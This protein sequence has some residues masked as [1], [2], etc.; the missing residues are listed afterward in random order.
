MR[1]LKDDE[2]EITLLMP[3]LNESETIGICVEK[4]M[5]SIKKNKLKGE[6]LIADNGS[7]D[8]SQ[9]IATKLGARVVSIPRKGYGSA[10]IGGTKEAKGKYIIMGDSD[11]SYD[12]S[13]IMP[14]VKELRKG[15]DL[16]MGNRFKGG[17]EEGAM[18]WAHKYIGTPVLSFLGRL[19]YR[20]KI[21]DFNCGMRGYNKESIL[22]LNLVCP[23]MEYAS[24]MIVKSA[25]N[26]LKIA[27][28]PTTLKKDGRS[29]A[30]YLRSFSDGWRHLKFLMF[31][32]PNWMFKIPS[33]LILFFLCIMSSLMISGCLPVK[34]LELSNLV[35]VFLSC[36][37]ISVQLMYLNKFALLKIKN[38]NIILDNDTEISFE[39]NLVLGVILLVTGIIFS[40]IC[41][42]LSIIFNGVIFIGLQVMFNS[43]MIGIMNLGKN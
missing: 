17:I 26:N 28:V 10:L 37:M 6:V 19:F 12:W 9:K 21:G 4:A 5:N 15:Y 24:E 36:I 14:Y 40:I 25:L 30:P 3:C 38:D 39:K 31:H 23:G 43:L 33:I 11:D 27:E 20:N 34:D 8:G 2:L 16:V 41:S 42:N 35:T 13:N 7:T 29:R 22:K 18:P 32:A 1:K